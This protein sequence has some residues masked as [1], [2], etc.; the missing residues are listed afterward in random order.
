MNR[1]KTLGSALLLTTALVACGDAAT[2]EADTE[3]AAAPVCDRS[4]L[5]EVANSYVSGLE[6]NSAD[7]VT[8]ADG[9]QIVENVNRIN[10]GEGLGT[11]ITGPGTDCSVTVPDETNQ[12][13]G[14]I[15]MVERDGEPTVVA[16]RIRLD[17]NGDISEA[18]HLYATVNEESPMGGPS[19]LAAMQTPRPGLLAEIP[20]GSRMSAAE[21]IAIGKTYYDALDD[22]DG[23]LM[24]F[25]D[26]C[27]RHENGI[28]T[29]GP[30]E[31]PGGPGDANAS[32]V[33]RDC[34]GQLTSNTMAYI[35]KIDN[36]RV[37]AADPVTGLVMGLSHFR[38]PMDFEPYPV[39]AIDGTT[40]L[41]SAD[42]GMFA[43]LGPFDLPAAHIFKIG[44]D[45]KVHEIEAMGFITDY[46]SPTGWESSAAAPANGSEAEG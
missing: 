7:G 40:T 25:A 13:V 9:V 6:S 38:H 31:R 34:A 10:V 36:R 29:A 24:P 19:P 11:D 27:R 42:E 30:G 12:T 4:C 46:N 22:N 45:G 33:A 41:R 32:P 15:G 21:L 23:S 18:E 44:A 35:T 14:W 1:F 28:E 3:V 5:I 8:F 39:T 20:E 26:D 16:L 17:G 2:D 37:F 43:D